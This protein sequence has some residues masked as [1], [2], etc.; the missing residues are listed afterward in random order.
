MKLLLA[1]I[2][3]IENY[4][5]L[6][7]FPLMLLFVFSATVSRTFDLGSIMWAEE[8]SRY[9]MIWLAFAGIGLGFKKNAHLGLSFVVNKFSQKVQRILYFV[10]AIIIALFGVLISY[11]TYSLIM[12]QIYNPQLSPSLG[13]P[14]WWVYLAILF[15][16]V[17]II[18]RSLQMS[19]ASIKNEIYA[20]D[21]EL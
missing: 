13:I 11:Y 10:R 16:S 6:I 9:L 21:A 5:L 8:A 12:T 17:L 1:K 14:I 2:N 19:W 3:N 20:E 7:T 18:I 15:G 4:I